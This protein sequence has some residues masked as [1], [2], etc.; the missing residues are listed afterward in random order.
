[1]RKAG[2]FVSLRDHGIDTHRAAGLERRVRIEFMFSRAAN[3]GHR[4]GIRD[5]VG[6]MKELLLS[7]VRGRQGHFLLESGHHGDLWYQL[8]TLCL[9]SRDIRRFAGQLA[10]QLARYEV[11]VVCGPLVE[12]AFI[13]LLVSLELGRDF[14]YAERFA[15]ARREGLFPVEYGLPKTLQPAVKGKRVAIVNDVVNAGSAVR[16][17]FFDLQEHGAEVVANGAEVVAIGALLALG[18]AINEFAGEHHISLELL[19][20]MPNNL[21]TP[22][23][24]PLCAEAMQLEIA[25]MS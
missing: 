4:V 17:T 2:L 8:E 25:S 12:G 5:Q 18:D 19:E 6:F 10:A 9:H 20:Q 22:S 13:A 1:L 14:A 16:G 7:L 24:C 21:W 15:D 23:E 3:Y 11:E